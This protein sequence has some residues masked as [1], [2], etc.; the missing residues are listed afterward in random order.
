MRPDALI[1]HPEIW[2]RGP[3]PY[4]PR[5]DD[6]DIFGGPRQHLHGLDINC[7]LPSGMPPAVNPLVTAA[8]LCLDTWWTHA[9]NAPGA[10]GSI[11]ACLQDEFT[12]LLV[13]CQNERAS[14]SS[15]LISFPTCLTRHRHFN[16]A[17]YNA[18]HHN[19]LED[20][21]RYGAMF[22]AFQEA[23]ATAIQ[24]RAISPR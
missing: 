10:R 9:M 3:Q 12:Y 8:V 2:P 20:E 17:G 15:M 14:S 5:F 11:V 16:M 13:G 18:K 1:I 19:V 4:L 21:L 23:N 24:F 7:E 22:C 6:R